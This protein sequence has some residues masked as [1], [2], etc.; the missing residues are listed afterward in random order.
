MGNNAST[1]SEGRGGSGTSSRRTSPRS[2]NVPLPSSSSHPSTA[3]DRPTGRRHRSIDMP[4]VVPPPSRTGSGT[5]AGRRKHSDRIPVVD[6]ELDPDPPEGP[7][8]SLRGALQ[9]KAEHVVY[10][11]RRDDDDVAAV[12]LNPP[13]LPATT[14]PSKPVAMAIPGAGG[15]GSG[16]GTRTPAGGAAGG[17]DGS[18]TNAGMGAIGADAMPMD[19]D[20]TTHPGFGAS[21]RLT[22]DVLMSTERMP[23]VGSPRHE[24]LPADSPF[25]PSTPA[26]TAQPPELKVTSQ[27]LASTLP[28][29]HAGSSGH[30][31]P[32]RNVV[33]PQ[34]SFAGAAS[35]IF[36]PTPA[37]PPPGASGLGGLP[38]S[39]HASSH[40]TSPIPTSSLLP[41]H[42][43]SPSPPSTAPADTVLAPPVPTHALPLA[44]D[45]IP[46][47]TSVIAS[48]QTSR[49]T[50][51]TGGIPSPTVLLPPQVFNHPVAAIP[52]PVLAV[53]S[54][55]LAEGLLAAAVDLGAGEEGVPTLIKWK[56]EDGQEAPRRLP[57][58]S[59]SQGKGP[60]EVYVTGTFAKG[61][62]TKIELRKTDPSDFSALISLP[63]GP[64]RLKFIVDNEW[65][66]S[67]HLPVAT[68]A[69][70]NLINYLHVRDNTA[71]A[72]AVRPVQ[73]ALAATQAPGQA[74]AASSRP[75]TGSS[76]G[77]A[78]AGTKAQQPKQLSPTQQGL[79]GFGT[80]GGLYWPFPAAEG[81]EDPSGAGANGGA[82]GANAW[83]AEDDQG[84]W[85][86][87]IPPE[88]LAW[89]EYEA[90]RDRVEGE[91][92]G[93]FPPGTDLDA[94]PGP[95]PST[96][97]PPPPLS[98][99]P[100]PSLP[101]Q[102]EK[103]PLNHAAYV[104]QG[105]GDDNSIL[106]KPDHSVINHLAASPIKGGFLSVGV[107]TR[108]KRKFVTIVYYKALGR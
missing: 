84:T 28:H 105:S 32:L 57:D 91:Y 67:K 97:P 21:A 27:D 14:A 88:L 46:S 56:N 74:S 22:S 26:A 58:G 89:G 44:A 103:G 31:T 64:H 25:R 35:A 104:T 70:G 87:A 33:A 8:G 71:N 81:E 98:H 96:Y 80:F 86:D 39:P 75:S 68:D 95:D 43:A 37:S 12:L 36:A 78:A 23:V 13:E 83:A 106:P 92:Y 100:P 63:P 72:A 79:P 5:G 19:P 50:T 99:V 54:S 45:H 101:A 66:A 24:D 15:R 11:P 102:L 53:Q 51:P 34:T 85:T 73:Q 69:D 4:D 20:D 1:P 6:E 18:L 59:M 3:H 41:P 49:G 9:G 48:P 90:E 16:S 38:I 107:T 76:A 61:W 62:K 40:S 47:G 29:S 65:K 17:R 7:R 77:G 2:R 82:G 10:G 42:T 55:S 60:Q 30:S 52:I 93:R 108:Y 94:L